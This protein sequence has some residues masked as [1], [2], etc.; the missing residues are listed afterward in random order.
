MDDFSQIFEERLKEIKSY[1]ELLDGLEQQVQQGT[2]KF[3]DDGKKITP[4]Q[5]KILYSSVYLQLYSLVEATIAGCISVFCQEII[6]KKY[7]PRQLSIKIR[8]EW[9]RFV[10]RTHA[11]V[12]YDNRL[13]NVLNL[14]DVLLEPISALEIEKGGG[15]N[16]DD[17]EIYKLIQRLGLSFTISRKVEADVKKPF[18]DGKGALALIKYL[19][20]KLAHGNISFVECAEDI[21]VADLRVLTDITASYL[22]EVVNCFKISIE[23]DEFLDTEK[24]SA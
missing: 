8:S 9:V 15:G 3:G 23:S 12:T 7:C 16:W 21:T 24:K 14:C 6:N 4:Q 19:R 2:P 5:Q 10:A 11:D 17:Q 20:N 18:R 13:K 22:R 1:L